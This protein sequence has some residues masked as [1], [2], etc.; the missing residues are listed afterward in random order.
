MNKYYENVDGKLFV[1]PI[2]ANHTGLTEITNKEFQS[3]L[4]IKNSLSHQY[5]IYLEI[6]KLE[7]TITPRRLRES[8]LTGDVSFINEV[9][10]K[11]ILKREKL[12]ESK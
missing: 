6:L 1:K 7:E 2:V 10:N 11:I 3:K 4:A 12:N 5:V 9:N 8:L